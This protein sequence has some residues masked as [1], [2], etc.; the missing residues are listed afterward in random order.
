M[1]SAETLLD[2]PDFQ[3]LF[4]TRTDASDQQLGAVTIKNIKPISLFK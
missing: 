3:I 4:T 2:Y 1:V